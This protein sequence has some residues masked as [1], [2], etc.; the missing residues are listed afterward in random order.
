MPD[1]ERKITLEELAAQPGTTDEI[2]EGYA[3][4]P[5]FVGVDGLVFDMSFG[6][7]GFYGPGGPYAKFAG[8]DVTRALALMKV[9]V[10][11]EES[12]DISD[13][14]EKQI[15]IMKDWVKTFRERKQYPVV[16]KLV[17]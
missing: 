4:A 14:T 16:G 3:A 1:P 9:D 7:V 15:G 2:P 13:C 5:I 12:A 8:R 10:A 11:E 17:K 6:G